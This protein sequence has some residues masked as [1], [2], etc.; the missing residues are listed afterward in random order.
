MTKPAIDINTLSIDEMLDL[1]DALE[2][3]LASIAKAE[4]GPMVQRLER[5]QGYL[6]TQIPVTPKAAAESVT[7]PKAVKTA[8]K[9]KR[10]K[11]SKPASKAAKRGKVAPKFRDPETGTTWTG[12]GRTPV[13]LRDY[14]AAGRKREEFSI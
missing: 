9:P 3:E 11:K 6:D 4:I 2:A 12:R 5:L 14:E 1:K 13:W 10:P 7:A 8:S